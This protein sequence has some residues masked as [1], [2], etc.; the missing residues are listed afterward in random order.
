MFR[1]SCNLNYLTKP[2]FSV[3]DMSIFVDNFLRCLSFFCVVCVVI[4]V[5]SFVIGHCAVELTL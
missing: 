4:I 5:A 2:V 3:E 1:M